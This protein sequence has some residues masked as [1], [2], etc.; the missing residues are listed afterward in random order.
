[1]KA[2]QCQYKYRNWLKSPYLPKSP[3][4]FLGCQVTVGH[5]TNQVLTFG[6]HLGKR[7]LAT[8]SSRQLAAAVNSWPP[9]GKTWYC[10]TKSP[11]CFRS[12]CCLFGCYTMLYHMGA[13]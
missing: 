7:F 9:A 2:K 6:G 10:A 13:P 12:C 3:G 4:N 11:N 8:G 1:M 5:V